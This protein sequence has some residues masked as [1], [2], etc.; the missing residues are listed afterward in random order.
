M[1]FLY[2]IF[3]L[4]TTLLTGSSMVSFN[5][6]KAKTGLALL[7][8]VWLYLSGLFLS[9]AAIQGVAVHEWLIPVTH[10][11]VHG[12]VVHKCLIPS[13]DLGFCII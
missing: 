6:Q 4:G 3:G 9:H 11:A 5:K 10:T 7:S 12:V 2:Q 1:S 13:T 8:M